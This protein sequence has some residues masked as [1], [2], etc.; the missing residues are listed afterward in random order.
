MQ[1]RSPRALPWA[2]CSNWA[3]S[4][5][6]VSQ[7]ALLP[8]GRPEAAKR[9]K[10]MVAKLDELGFGTCTTTRACEAVCP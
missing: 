7:F 9:A 2:E 1:H 10:A 4:P 3:Y 5:P 8:Q 6:Q